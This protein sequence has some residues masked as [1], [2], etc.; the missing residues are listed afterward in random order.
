MKHSAGVLCW[1]SSI[2]WIPGTEHKRCP[3]AASASRKVVQ[4]LGDPSKKDPLAE[5]HL[6][7]KC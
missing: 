2:P 1:W 7:P 6:Q 5:F 3:A 4:L